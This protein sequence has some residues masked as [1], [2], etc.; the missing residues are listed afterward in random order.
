MNI[1]LYI[2]R[3][4]LFSS[5]SKNAV[6]V[7]TAISVLG[8]TVG[9]LSLVV[10]LSV[11]NGFESLIK[12]MYNEVNADFV[13]RSVQSKSF[14]TLDYDYDKL[15]ESVP[16]ET[17]QEVHEEKVLLKYEDQEQIAKLRGVKQWPLTDSLRIEKHLFRG[18]S[19]RA[20]HP[21]HHAIVGQALAHTLSISA[22]QYYMPLKVF[23]PNASAKVGSLE[24]PFTERS[25]YVSGL[26]AVQASFDASYVITSLASVQE[27]LDKPQ[28][29]TSIEIQVNESDPKSLQDEIQAFFGPDFEVKNRY[30]QQE[31]L[32]KVLQTEK[33][34]IFFILAFI[35]LI[36]TFTIV[37]SVVMIVLEKRKDI[38]SLWAMGAKESVI[39][40]IF[41]Y[42]GLLITFFGGALG[43]F[44]GVAL[45]LAQQKFGFIQIGAQGSFIVNNY[46]VEVQSADVLMIMLTVL[47]L[48]ALVTW[49]PV[50]LLKR[51]FI[52]AS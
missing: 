50:R 43:I 5:K 23:V 24:K 49:I 20:T 45:C 14:S 27:F 47:I 10:V 39:Q 18:K 9:T 51:K 48:G 28:R 31:F 16:W 6:N 13:V 33:W 52:E 11:F 1:A 37:A 17:L 38:S 42:E 36:A 22:D 41:F 15:K 2:A 46:P 44:L 4:Y 32:Y 8:V 40:R 25:W 3:R 19:F 30:Q 21:H 34:A 7:I 26:Y 12:S 35:L 29:V